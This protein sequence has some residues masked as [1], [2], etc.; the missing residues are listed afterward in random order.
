MN[1]AI[2]SAMP[3]DTD[4]PSSLFLKQIIDTLTE[5]SIQVSLLT[6]KQLTSNKFQTGCVQRHLSELFEQAGIDRIYLA[7]D[8]PITQEARKWCQKMRVQHVDLNLS[9]RTQ[10]RPTMSPD[11]LAEAIKYVYAVLQ[12]LTTLLFNV[13]RS[14]AK[15]LQQPLTV[16][17]YNDGKPGHT[18]QL[19]GLL[20]EL[21]K[22]A[23]INVKWIDVNS[24]NLSLFDTIKKLKQR[25][26]KV[27]IVLGAGHKTHF[28][29]LLARLFTRAKSIVLMKPGLP[30]SW[31]DLALI[32]EHDRVHGKPNIIT[33]T[34]VLNT[35]TPSPQKDPT[36]GLVLLGGPSKHFN[37][38]DA[39]LIE[40]IS[41]IT[42]SQP[43]I[44]W[45][46]T[47][48]RRTPESFIRLLQASS[49]KIRLIGYDQTHPNWVTEKLALASQT[50]VSEDSTSMLFEAL[51]SGTKVGVLELSSLKQGRLQRCIQRLIENKKIISYSQWQQSPVFPLNASSLH[52]SA[53]C[54]N[55]MLDYIID[56]RQSADHYPSTP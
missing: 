16:W 52:E 55:L 41:R 38:D 51:T 25:C 10:V 23:L 15:T 1:V 53:R 29:M 13:G 36:K 45:E 31:F 27:D 32:P 35:I 14:N 6:T 34:G 30:I 37:W 24:Q 7:G 28:P 21:K 43:H 49:A 2:V 56:D 47:T 19:R 11:Q 48:S 22:Y 40:Q 9:N 54:A 3:L 26:N 33:T 4:S 44:N 42:E 5:Q 17:V 46:L 39:S 8:K 50:W 12:V 18:N 20:Q